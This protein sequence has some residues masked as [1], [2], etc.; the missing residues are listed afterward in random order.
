MATSLRPL[1]PSESAQE[2]FPGADCSVGRPPSSP[3]LLLITAVANVQAACENKCKERRV[4][5]LR[6]CW[7]DWVTG[8]F[9]LYPKVFPD[10]HLRPYTEKCCYK[11]SNPQR[12]TVTPS[13]NWQPPSWLST[14]CTHHTQCSNLTDCTH[15]VSS[16]H[17]PPSC[18]AVPDKSLWGGRSH[19]CNIQKQKQKTPN[20]LKK[21][22]ESHLGMGIL[23]CTTE[24]GN[25][26][27]S[28]Y[29]LTFIEQHIVYFS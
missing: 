5:W 12:L 4:M 1:R 7:E 2:A 10:T 14:Y 13:S 28:V 11:S 18:P 20:N 24:R 16:H 26:S 8:K 15:L 6:N 29:L 27:F 22:K 21:Q 9:A 25:D 23:D 19:F 17:P 3:L